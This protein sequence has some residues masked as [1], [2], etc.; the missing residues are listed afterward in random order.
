MT[1]NTKRRFCTQ[2][3][4]DKAKADKNIRDRLKA[5]IEDAMELGKPSIIAVVNRVATER[6]I[7]KYTDGLGDTNSLY[8]SRDYAQSSI[9]GT[10]IAPPSFLAAIS[11]WF[12]GTL[13]RKVSKIELAIRS[14]EAGVKCE[15]F[16][17][18]RE[19]D[20]FT[21]VEIPTEVIDITREKSALQ[22]LTLGK[23][24]YKNQRSEVVGILT[25]T[26][27]SI[28]LTRPPDKPAGDFPDTLKSVLGPKPR[29][30]TIKE[31]ED[32]YNL[33]E[34]EPVRG[35][36]FRFWEDVNVG[37]QLP[38]THR[39][40]TMMENVAFTSGIGTGQG[41]WRYTMRQR[42][43]NTANP[44]A[45]WR[46]TLDPESHLPDFSGIHMTDISGLRQGIPKANAA[47][48]QLHC[49]MTHLITNW[50]GDAG[51]LKK[52]DEQV[53]RS[54]WRGSL[55][56]CKGEVVKK[57]IEDDEHL[58]DLKITMEDH[59]GD[60]I[61]PNG[62]ATVVLPSRRM[63]NSIKNAVSLGPL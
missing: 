59:W 31:I 27:A 3:E 32:W 5:Q 26:S 46:K 11:W 58:V 9:H 42:M 49:W 25:S 63:E 14:F 35:G 45:D 28:I 60:M 53:R 17:V 1:T 40:W 7:K 48:V 55:A 30:F 36:E 24:V 15:W 18:I 61:I 43:K 50:M 47:G 2:E 19:G 51:F 57:Y 39:V 22:F 13:S 4:V 20:E 21:C 56:I 34:A 23:K 10:I 37:D 62:K 12:S 52:I 44:L 6:A 16:R 38:P 54:L 29:Q 8:R 33:M 41:N